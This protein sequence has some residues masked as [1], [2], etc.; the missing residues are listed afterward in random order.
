M[1]TPIQVTFQDVPPSDA[2]EAAVRDE[3]AA[4]ERYYDRITSC[5]VTVSEPH[6]HQHQG[7]LYRVRIHMAVPG[8][9]LVVDREHGGHAGHADPYLAVREAFHAARRELEDYVREMRGD[10]KGREGPSRGRIVRLLPWEDCGFIESADRRELYF[11]RHSVLRGN[12][13]ELKAGDEVTFVEEE[14]EKGSNA[15]SVRL[16]SRAPKGLPV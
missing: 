4:L 5:H 3:A 2:L 15:K 10:V 7:R 1:Q 6:R 16:A 13:D 14:A 11:H 9:D 12:F 8:D